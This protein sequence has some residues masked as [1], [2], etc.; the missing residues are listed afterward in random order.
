MFA[1]L[2]L[3]M[4]NWG[5]NDNELYGGR[6]KVLID[7][8]LLSWELRRAFSTFDEAEAHLYHP[9]VPDPQNTTSDM[10]T[11]NPHWETLTFY[12]AGFIYCLYW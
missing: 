8:T 3:S 9:L 7:S 2:F 11:I 12:Y 5:N 4:L 10:M 1:N 6:I